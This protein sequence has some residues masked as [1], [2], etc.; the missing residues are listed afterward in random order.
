MNQ[1]GSEEWK[2][3]RIGKATGSRISDIITR[4]KS[5][6]FSAMRKAYATQLA[7][8]RISKQP[9]SFQPNAAMQHGT[10]TEPLARDAYKATIFEDVTEVGFI[11]HPSILNSGASPDGLVGDDGLVEIKCPESHTHI[12]TVLDGV[13]P[14]K[15]FPQIQWQLACTERKY[16]DFVSYDPRCPENLQLFVRRV[17]RD[18]CFIATTEELVRRFLTEVDELTQQ[19]NNKIKEK[20]G[21]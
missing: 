4:L 17:E 11:N 16:C 12:S 14:E 13:V 6:G 21:A 10:N 8:E 1:Q 9:Y 15:Y 19:L 3:D 2:A 7:L 20:Q 5:G 18:D